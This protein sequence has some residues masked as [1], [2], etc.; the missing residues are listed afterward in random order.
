MSDAFRDTGEVLQR[1]ADG[2]QPS[3]YAEYRTP[4]WW[5]PFAKSL[6]GWRVWATDA[7]FYARLPHTS[8][9][10]VVEAENPGALCRAVRAKLREMDE[11]Q[12]PGSSFLP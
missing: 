1:L 2:H 6:P 8:P 4:V 7:G 12:N 9:L 3:H 10:V 5:A 11:Q